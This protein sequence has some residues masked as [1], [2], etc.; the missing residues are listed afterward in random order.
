MV[1]VEPAGGGGE[2]L[3]PA[4]Q[5]TGVGN[6]DDLGSYIPHHREEKDG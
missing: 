5:D 2:S 6:E 3:L 4:S 1:M